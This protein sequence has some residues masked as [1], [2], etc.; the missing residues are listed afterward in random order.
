VGLRRAGF[1]SD[2]RLAIKEAIKSFFFRGLNATAAIDEI[3]KANPD[4]GDIDKFIEF[5]NHSERGIMPGCASMVALGT[6]RAGGE[7]KCTAA[8]E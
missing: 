4:N 3:R 1:D 7:E 6:R 8:G 2:R 5:I